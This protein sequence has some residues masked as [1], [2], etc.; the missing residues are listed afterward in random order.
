M[1]FKRVVV[2]TG[3]GIS[4][5]SGIRT[6]RDQNGLW[7]DHPVEDV[8]TPEGFQR[9]PNLVYQFYNM[10]RAQ[11]LDASVVPNAAHQI[12]AEF[13]AEHIARGGHFTLI[14]QN[15]DN[16]HQR[17]GNQRI[18]AM[19]GQLQSALCSV[20]GL[21]IPWTNDLTAEHHCQ[22]CE[23]PSSLRPDIVWFGEVPYQL[24]DCFEVVSKAD[25][26]VSIGTSGKVYPAAG[27][28]QVAQES[29][30]ETVE[31]NLEKTSSAFDQG[32][33]GPAT[34]VVVDFFSRLM[35]R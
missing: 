2:L 28:M 17:A 10:R 15:V 35:Q 26:F 4:A 25:L 1:E 19:H 3:A 5:E 18:I 24:D 20:S 8:A 22:C 33:Y 21:S 29:G 34:E 31:L 27:F 23:T 9:N 14:T 11:L 30:A 7:E 16:L 6:F 13:E 12:L 32:Y